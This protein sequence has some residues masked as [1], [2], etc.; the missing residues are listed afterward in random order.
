MNASAW[1]GLAVGIGIGAIAAGAVIFTRAQK[2]NAERAAMAE[3]AKAEAA[4]PVSVATA[5]PNAPTIT[6]YKTATCGCCKLWVSYLQ[7]NG[8]NV[9]AKDI[10]DAELTSFTRDKGV[11]D[12]LSSCH[13]AIVNGYV[14]EGHVPVADIKKMLAEKPNIIGLT[15]PG[16]VPGT[17]GMPG[18]TPQHYDVLAIDKQGHS[19]VYSKN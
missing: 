13:T 17:P 18:A 8:Y 9:V 1:K 12:E 4:L 16:M 3:A 7:E 6:V 14:L 11:P 15:V 5:D 10:S 2:L 19:T